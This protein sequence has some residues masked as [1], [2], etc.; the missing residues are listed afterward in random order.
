MDEYEF[1]DYTLFLIACCLVPI[2]WII[3]GVIMWVA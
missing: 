1:N 3:E 2:W